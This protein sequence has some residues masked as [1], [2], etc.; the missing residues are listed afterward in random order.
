MKKKFKSFYNVFIFLSF[1]TIFS[2]KKDD[3]S[4]PDCE[5]FNINL[6][7]IEQD[8]QLGAQADSAFTA[9]LKDTILDPAKYSVAYGHLQ[10]ITNKILNEQ[11]INK[12]KFVWKVRIINQNVLNAFCT[13]GGY[14]YVY[15]GIIKYLDNEDDLAGV[16]G[17][18][19]AHADL[20]HSS[21]MI[22]R[23]IGRETIIS[24]LLGNDPGVLKDI[25]AGLS[26]LKYSRCHESEADAYSVNYLSPTD[27]KCNGAASFFEKL[28]A[29][30]QSGGTPT[31]LS[32]HPDP[33]DRV[34]KINQRAAEK[35]CKTTP[36]STNAQYQAFKASLP[37]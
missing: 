19:I 3:P 35:G 33:G 11:V 27:Y 26:D 14:I 10:R 20:R 23:Q 9:D 6:L 2:C 34:A 22:T 12:D 18:E 36:S 37:Q 24:F 25:V 32:T 16:L 8:N 4:L 1:L 21:K 5:T 15:T 30:G 17:H 29:E 31:F 13:P 7:S 28:V